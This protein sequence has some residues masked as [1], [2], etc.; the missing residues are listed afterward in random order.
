MVAAAALAAAAAVFDDVLTRLT[1]DVAQRVLELAVSGP[2]LDGFRLGDVDPEAVQAVARL[3][4]R[5]RS[6]T[7]L[8]S[9]TLRN[10]SLTAANGIRGQVA[11]SLDGDG[12]GRQGTAVAVGA[13]VPLGTDGLLWEIGRLQQPD[14]ELF[15]PETAQRR[16][17][18]AGTGTRTWTGAGTGTGVGPGEDP[19]QRHSTTIT[20][21]FTVTFTSTNTTTVTTTTTTTTTTTA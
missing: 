21:S 19:R 14:L 10:D 15:H 16:G 17:G 7:F 5:R 3:R 1:W 8:R 13:L 2:P 9:A 20:V 4:L 12:P 11:R 18:L 6:T